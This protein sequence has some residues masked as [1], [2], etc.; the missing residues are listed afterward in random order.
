MADAGEEGDGVLLEAHP[1]AAAVAQAAAGQLGL[2]VLHR[3][4]QAGGQAL[5][6]DDEAL[7]VA[8]PRGQEADHRC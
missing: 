7:A 6:D 2:H 5:D 4:G 3:H 1:G 8:L